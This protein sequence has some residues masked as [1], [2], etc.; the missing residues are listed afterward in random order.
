M[1]ERFSKVLTNILSC[2]ELM[3]S[4]SRG[5]VAIMDPLVASM[6]NVLSGLVLGSNEYRTPLSA[7]GWS[8]SI[9]KAFPI[10]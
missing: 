4:R 5:F 7:R 9:A 3:V 10:S 2:T 6:I 1:K 8:G